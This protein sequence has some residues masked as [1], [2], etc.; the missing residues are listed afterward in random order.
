MV[1]VDLKCLEKWYDKLTVSASNLAIR[2][3]LLTVLISM[4][5]NLALSIV[6]SPSLFITVLFFG[7]DILILF[8]VALILST[9]RMG[10]GSRIMLIWLIS[11]F[12]MSCS[13]VAFG[14]VKINGFVEKFR[15]IFAL[16]LLI[17]LSNLNLRDSPDVKPIFKIFIVLCF[18]EGLFLISGYI[19]AYREFVGVSAYLTAKNTT[20]NFG[21][22][23]FNTLRLATPMFQPS[24]GGV[25][26][27]LI[28]IRFLQWRNYLWSLATFFVIILT[29]SK[30]GLM[31]LFAYPLMLV[32]PFITSLGLFI[33]PFALIELLS[34]IDLK[35]IYSIRYHFAGFFDGFDHL[36]SP[37]GVGLSGTV[38]SAPGREVGA[39][40]GIGA[41]LSAFGIFGFVPLVLA[42]LNQKKMHF[43]VL[44]IAAVIYTEISMNLYVAII[45]YFASFNED[46]NEKNT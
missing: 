20:V 35:H 27:A 16:P 9:A 41:Y 7:R 39:E 8:S 18:V 26:L 11:A 45:F 4:F 31:L 5:G 30:T 12:I 25:V 6:R 29:L 32:S 2:I 28:L 15:N 43:V 10:F 24:L 33:T 38:L 23:L 36:F 42:Y 22:G 37:V 19:G 3:L 34:Q 1:G 40:S 14:D 46:F 13:F 21:F 17:L 44:Y